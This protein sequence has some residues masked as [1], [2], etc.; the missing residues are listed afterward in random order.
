VP[1]AAW[2]SCNDG[3][4]RREYAGG[5]IRHAARSRSTSAVARTTLPSPCFSNLQRY[6]ILLSLSFC[7]ITPRYV[8]HAWSALFL[9]LLAALQMFFADARNRSIAA[10]VR[11]QHFPHLNIVTFEQVLWIDLFCINQHSS[12]SSCEHLVCSQVAP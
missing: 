5:G 12:D 6:T 11:V 9:E 7:N 8:V 3:S 2:L 1:G 4:K 10:P